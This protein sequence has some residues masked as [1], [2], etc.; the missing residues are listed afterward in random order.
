MMH[1]A[2]LLKSPRGP[3][4]ARGSLLRGASGTE[5][6]NNNKGEVGGAFLK[7]MWSVPG[8]GGEDARRGGETGEEEEGA[9]SAACCRRNRILGRPV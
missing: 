3:E 2:S 8:T 7:V 5:G 4:P 1:P 6:V 9:E